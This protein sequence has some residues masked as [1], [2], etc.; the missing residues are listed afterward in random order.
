[1]LSS[2][3]SLKRIKDALRGRMAYML[4]GSVNEEEVDLAVQLGVP[5]LGPAPYTAKTLSRKS[6]ARTL[7]KGAGASYL[8]SRWVSFIETPKEQPKQRT[9]YVEAESRV[10]KLLS[11]AMVRCPTVNKWLMKVDDESLGCGHAFFEGRPSF[12]E[13]SLVEQYELQV[14]SSLESE[15]LQPLS[16]E[17]QVSAYRIH[18]LLRVQ[19]PRALTLAAKDV[20]RTYRAYI[21]KLAERGGVIEACPDMTVGSPCVN[22]FIAPSGQVGNFD[23]YTGSYEVE[24]DPP[25]EDDLESLSLSAT[26]QQE[27]DEGAGPSTSQLPPRNASTSSRAG[28]TRGASSVAGPISSQ[29]FYFALDLVA[30]SGIAKTNCAQF[31]HSC[32][33]EGFHYDVD[34]RMGVIFNLSDKYI[35]GALGV[36][37]VGMVPHEIYSVMQKVLSFIA[38]RELDMPTSQKAA[39]NVAHNPTSFRDLQSL[40]KYM[41]EKSIAVSLGLLGPD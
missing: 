7:F 19:L 29:R 35:S 10:L 25:V 26:G 8:P 20:F 32:W 1:M 27:E 17:Q 13:R 11:E 28:S 6:A 15:P 36:L 16:E 24:L 4:P 40:V 2:P 18:E 41:A 31:F 34:H 3:H 39:W 5:M 9:E 12:L 21:M 38:N 30:H 23:P 22:I 14:N 37:A 33:Q